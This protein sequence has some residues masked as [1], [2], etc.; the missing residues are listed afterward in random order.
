MT[1]FSSI[2]E[3]GVPSIRILTYNIWFENITMERME[4]ILKIIEG[5]NPDFICLQEVTAETRSMI[6][7]SN[8]IKKGY[9]DVG[10]CASCN[11]FRRGSFYG[12]MIISRF[13]CLFF[14]RTFPTDMGRS[15]IIAEPCVPFHLLIATSHFES[16]DSTD[17]RKCQMTSSFKLLN[18]AQGKEFRNH[19][20][21][22]GDFNFD[23]TWK[24]EEDVLVD[25]GYKD[26]MHDYVDKEEWTMHKTFRFAAWRPDKVVTQA[27]PT[28]EEFDKPYWKSIRAEI[29]GK[30]ATPSFIA[31]G[32]EPSMIL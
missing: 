4:C 10:G 30:E 9:F 22:V 32:E 23:S 17:M 31:K 27:T 1:N 29:V 15:L 5:K 16:L 13:P 19:S 24:A 21:L 20:V 14:E 26:I 28:K 7:E 12:S 6:L 11:N 8:T 3:A 25:N 18:K 2:T